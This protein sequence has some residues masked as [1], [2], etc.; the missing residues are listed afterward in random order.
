MSL[1]KLS[2]ISLIP[3]SEG[4]VSDIPAGD[5]KI[6]ILFLQ[7]AF[8]LV[9]TLPST[10]LML[11]IYATI[12]YLAPLHLPLSVSFSSVASRALA[13]QIHTNPQHF[14]LHSADTYPEPDTDELESECSFLH[15][16]TVQM[17][18]FK[19]AESSTLPAVW[20]SPVLLYMTFFTSYFLDVKP[21]NF[22]FFFSKILFIFGK[23]N[24]QKCGLFLRIYK[25]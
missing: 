10:L 19:M 12:Y 1:T 16:V 22:F 18:F 6:S 23:Q 7:C 2:L 5:G 8:S 17:F 9:K 3:T 20:G 25:C 4:L 13:L 21:K 15:V 14:L 24:L 11:Y